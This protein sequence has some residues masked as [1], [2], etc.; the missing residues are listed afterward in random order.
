MYSLHLKNQSELDEVA[1]DFVNFVVKG[2]KNI[3]CPLGISSFTAVKVILRKFPSC[4]SILLT[5]SR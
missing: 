3:Q 5:V 4:I 1:F 2:L